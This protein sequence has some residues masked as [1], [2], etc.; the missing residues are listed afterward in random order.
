MLQADKRC[1]LHHE[2][3]FQQSGVTAELLTVALPDGAQCP[4]SLLFFALGFVCFE[5]GSC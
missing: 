2:G 5:E 3:E 1:R 4:L